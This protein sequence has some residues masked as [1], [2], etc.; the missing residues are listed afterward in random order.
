[1]E[2]KKRKVYEQEFKRAAVRPAL[3]ED[4]EVRGV[5]RELGIHENLIHRWK[6]EYIV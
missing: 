3:E 2:Y 5:C 4:R 1:M 6:S